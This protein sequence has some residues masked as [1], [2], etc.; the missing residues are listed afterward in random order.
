MNF[1]SWFLSLFLG[2]LADIKGS[3]NFELK[4]VGVSHYQS[5]L[6]EI[7]GGKNYEG[8]RLE[9]AAYLIHENDNPY[10]KNAIRVEIDGRTVGHLSRADAFKFREAIVKLGHPGI[11]AKCNA[12]IV[13]GWDAGGGDKGHY[14]VRLDFSL[15]D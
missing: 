12:I 5:I 1:L 8:H 7:C 6:D 13:G 14:G 10:D 2:K 15:N 3:G 9:I 4:V 11:D